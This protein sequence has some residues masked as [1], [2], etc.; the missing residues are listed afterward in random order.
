MCTLIKYRWLPVLSKYTTNVKSQI[1][2]DKNLFERS[3]NMVEAI[4]EKAEI[5]GERI[6][7]LFELTKKLL[8]K[9]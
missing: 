2:V 6:P 8:K 3:H 1:T 7:I 9:Y 4:V 5:L